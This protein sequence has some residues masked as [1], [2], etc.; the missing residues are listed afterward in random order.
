LFG[1]ETGF[2]MKVVKSLIIWIKGK[3]VRKKDKN[4]KSL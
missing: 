1:L 4:Y 3:I 2:E